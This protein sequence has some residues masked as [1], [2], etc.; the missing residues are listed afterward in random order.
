MEDNKYII[1]V[2]EYQHIWEN[3]INFV[4]VLQF[5]VPWIAYL[6]STRWH[7]NLQ[8]NA[9]WVYGRL[10]LPYVY[11]QRGEQIG[12]REMV[13]FFLRFYKGL[14]MVCCEP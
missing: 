14:D 12:Y 4:H 8:G 3:Y 5:S 11:C 9:S 13:M 10:D 6:C 1:S 2:S 7:S